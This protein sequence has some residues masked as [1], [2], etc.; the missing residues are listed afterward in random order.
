MI[1][2][3]SVAIRRSL[4]FAVDLRCASGI[5]QTEV[6]VAHMPRVETEVSFIGRS[7]NDLWWRDS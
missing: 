5:D 1:M 6:T 4:I 3:V 7:V 2:S